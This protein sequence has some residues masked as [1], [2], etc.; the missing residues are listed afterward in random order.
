MT[1]SDAEALL[2]QSAKRALIDVKSIHVA[3]N[4]M[5]E[6]LQLLTEHD[7]ERT[8]NPPLHSYAHP[9]SSLPRHTLQM[10]CQYFSVCFRSLSQYT[11]YYPV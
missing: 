5:E 1:F 9:Y 7:I 10:Y 6:I 11:L 4:E 3:T 2:F 8:N